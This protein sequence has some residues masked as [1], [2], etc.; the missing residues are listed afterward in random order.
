MH[1]HFKNRVLFYFLLLICSRTALAQDHSFSQFWENR[2]YYNPAFVGLNVGELNGLLTYK[3]LWPKFP[4]NFSTIHFSADMKTYNSYG[5]GLYILSSDEGSGFI[6]SN[7]VGISYS[8][9]GYFN[10]EKNIYFQLGLKGSYNDERLDFNKYIYSGNLHEIYGNIIPITQ[11]L[12]ENINEKQ[13]YWDFSAGCMVY[14]PWERHYREFMHNFIGFS[15]NHLTRPKDNFIE[16]D[17]RIPMKIS[18]QWNSFIRTDLYSLDRKS[19]LYICPG[20]LFEN[21]G[22]QLMSSSS[23]NNVVAVADLTTDPLFGGIW[24]SSQLLNS[25]KEKTGYKIKFIK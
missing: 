14:I 23:F 6:K 18:L 10:K 17:A 25:S 21:Q 16:D 5:F 2:T 4:G 1:I 8:W 20:L 7:T 13:H 19:S 11:P 9:R 12:G 15:V 3:K 24:Y 22:D